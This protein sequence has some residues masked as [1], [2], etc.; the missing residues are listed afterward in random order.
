MRQ[1]ESSLQGGILCL[2]FNEQ[3][4]NLKTALADHEAFQ[5]KDFFADYKKP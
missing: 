1:N 5:Q 2:K 4:R 3:A